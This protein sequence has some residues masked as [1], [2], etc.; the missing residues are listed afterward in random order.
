MSLNSNTYY[1]YLCTHFTEAFLVIFG[2]RKASI[3]HPPYRNGEKTL[4]KQ[5]RGRK[6]H[7]NKT[8]PVL[9]FQPG[10]IRDLKA[11]QN[12]LGLFVTANSIT[13]STTNIQK[14]NQ[15][16]DCWWTMMLG[17]TPSFANFNTQKGIFF[18]SNTFL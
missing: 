13:N 4:R 14:L 3:R 6:E 2:H 18:C 7:K 12:T 1:T 16:S 11:C 15:C 5:Q 9:I 8:L 10:G 17:Y